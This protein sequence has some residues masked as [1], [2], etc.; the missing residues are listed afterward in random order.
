[1]ILIQHHAPLS[2]RYRKAINQVKAEKL[3]KKLEHIAPG[4]SD[5]KSYLNAVYLSY[6]LMQMIELV[7]LSAEEHDRA[8]EL[9]QESCRKLLADLDAFRAKVAQSLQ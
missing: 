1:M 8:K 6:N 9:F 2:A 5:G 7:E 3:A 4:L